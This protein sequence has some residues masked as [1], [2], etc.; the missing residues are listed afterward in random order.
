[1]VITFR[2]H[3]NINPNTVTWSITYK[4]LKFMA[5]LQIPTVLLLSLFYVILSR[6]QPPTPG[7]I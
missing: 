5:P 7:T 3:K 2:M 1:M 4:S 6:A